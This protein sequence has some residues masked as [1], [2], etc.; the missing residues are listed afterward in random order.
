MRARAEDSSVITVFGKD[1]F[2]AWNE[3]HENKGEQKKQLL[4]SQLKIY[5]QNGKSKRSHRLYT[6]EVYA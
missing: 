4:Q 1:K 6:F 3:I 2:G 5:Q